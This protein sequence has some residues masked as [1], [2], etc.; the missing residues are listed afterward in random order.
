MFV[1]GS[2]ELEGIN[3]PLLCLWTTCSPLS[4][5]PSQQ[6]CGQAFAVAVAVGADAVVACSLL[7]TML[8]W[9]SK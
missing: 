4:I 3:L 9:N 1:R 8:K 7:S 6:T 5:L 2:K